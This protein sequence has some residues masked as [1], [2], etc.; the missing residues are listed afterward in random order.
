MGSEPRSGNV[1][2]IAGLAGVGP[3]V[4][5]E[6]LVEFQVDELGELGWAEVAGVRLLT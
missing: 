5:V 6:S 3:L 2:L 4:G 1:L